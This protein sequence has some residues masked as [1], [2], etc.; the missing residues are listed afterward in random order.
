[1]TLAGVG[2]RPVRGDEMRALVAVDAERALC[3]HEA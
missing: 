3:A 2:V 1:V